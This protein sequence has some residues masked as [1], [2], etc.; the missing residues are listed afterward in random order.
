VWLW[1]LSNIRYPNE[2]ITEK[3]PPHLADVPKA[4]VWHCNTLA[5][6]ATETFVTVL[7]MWDLLIRAFVAVDQPDIDVI[8]FKILLQG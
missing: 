6:K 1:V 3:I 8:V 7:W 4:M 2:L 5:Y